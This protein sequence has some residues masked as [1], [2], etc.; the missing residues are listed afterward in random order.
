MA[1]NPEKKP[2]LTIS[3]QGKEGCVGIHKNVVRALGCPRYLAP[4]ISRKRNL[5]MLVP[6]EREDVLSLEM[7]ENF[8]ES[9]YT[10]YR[11]HSLGF[12][13]DI[14][15]S[16]G[17]KTECTYFLEGRYSKKNHAVIFPI[18]EKLQ[19]KVIR[20]SGLK[21]VIECVTDICFK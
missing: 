17:L 12:V 5:F 21:T 1:D 14:L 20:L 13:R 16:N 10:N 11:I 8:L 15:L 18:P 9:A 7:P 19:S 4:R 3:I 6:C 2:K